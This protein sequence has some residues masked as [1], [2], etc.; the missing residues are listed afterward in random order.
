MQPLPRMQNTSLQKV[1]QKSS[2]LPN[3]EEEQQQ[4]VQSQLWSHWAF[5]DLIQLS[6]ATYLSFTIVA[7]LRRVGTWSG[8]LVQAWLCLSKNH[9]VLVLCFQP[10]KH[11]SLGCS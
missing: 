9:E 10:Q 4:A 11:T 6:K 1:K 7:Q 2:Q 3:E 8:P 5:V